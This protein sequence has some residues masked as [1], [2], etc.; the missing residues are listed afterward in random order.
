MRC[1]VF[2]TSHGYIIQD[3][4]LWNIPTDTKGFCFWQQLDISIL[5]GIIKRMI[6]NPTTK[7]WTE[8][9]ENQLWRM[10]CITVGASGRVCRDVYGRLLHDMAVS[11]FDCWPKL[12]KLKHLGVSLPRMSVKYLFTVTR[13]DL[14]KK[15]WK[16]FCWKFRFVLIFWWI[17]SEWRPRPTSEG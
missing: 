5:T 14:P 2:R 4:C 9:S 13:W 6:E 10:I 8:I 16:I 1:G 7:V 17:E 12:S 11:R 15:V 3:C